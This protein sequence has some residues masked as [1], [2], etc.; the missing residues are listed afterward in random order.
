[1]PATK[2]IQ[3]TLST[4]IE[5]DYLNGL[6]KKTV[7]YA[8]ISPRMVNPRDIAGERRRRTTKTVWIKVGLPE[9]FFVVVVVCFSY[10]LYRLTEKLGPVSCA[11]CGVCVCER[12]R[13]RESSDLFSK[14][15]DFKLR[16]GGRWG[17][18]G[19]GGDVHKRAKEQK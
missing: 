16:P 19:G 12:E 15:V 8:K 10:E 1:M 11:K 14:D 9:Q 17:G 2:H 7:K 4:K 6:I 13:E 3:Q 5:C 18:G